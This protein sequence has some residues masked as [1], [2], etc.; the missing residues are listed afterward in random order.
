MNPGPGVGGPGPGVIGCPPGVMG[1]PM[2]QRTAQIAFVGPDG[3]CIAWDVSGTGVFNEMPL[4]CP[5]KHNFPENGLYRLKLTN[6]PMRPGVELYPTLEVGPAMPRTS[7]FLAHNPIP[8]QFTDEDFNQ[9]QSGNMVT[10]V[11]YLPDPEYQ[12][13]AMAGIDT[14]VSTRL[15]PGVD[16]IM[17]A[18]SRGTILAIIRLGNIDLEIPGQT[19]PQLDPGM[20]AGVMMAPGMGAPTAPQAYISGVTGPAY[21]A[22]IT[23]TPI[24][25]PGPIY[26]PQGAPAGLKRHVMHNYTPMMIP[27]PTATVR[28]GMM[29]NPQTYPKPASNVFIHEKAMPSAGAMCPPP[30]TGLQVA[31]SAMGQPCMDCPQY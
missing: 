17:E 20:N 29:Q 16:P 18:D 25:L 28:V 13:L 19:P 12:E 9:V 26:V 5:S 15:D 6:I 11:I 22:P 21:G 3:M 23:G 4:I 10:K 30:G 27:E 8:V 2:Q 31:P 7:A 1:M 24:G 14:L